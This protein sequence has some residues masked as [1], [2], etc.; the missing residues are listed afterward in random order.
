MR[1]T[2][3][4]KE[5]TNSKEIKNGVK[6]KR[7]LGFIPTITFTSQE[8]D[9]FLKFA[10]GDQALNDPISSD[11]PFERSQS[12]VVPSTVIPKS[13]FHP[14]SG[15]CIQD[16]NTKKKYLLSHKSCKADMFCDICEKVFCKEECKEQHKAFPCRAI[17][18]YHFGE[19]ITSR[20]EDQIENME[21]TEDEINHLEDEV[22]MMERKLNI[23]YKSQK[24][25]YMFAVKTLQ[26]SI[27]TKLKLIQ[28]EENDSRLLLSECKG[29]MMGNEHNI[30]TIRSFGVKMREHWE[31]KHYH[32]IYASRNKI[33]KIMKVHFEDLPI[34]LNDIMTEANQKIGEILGKGEKIKEFFQQKFDDL[35]DFLITTKDDLVEEMAVE[36]LQANFHISDRVLHY[37]IEDSH[38]FY[39]FDIESL[40]GKKMEVKNMKIPYGFDSIQ[41]NSERIFLCGGYES[42]YGDEYLKSTYEFIEESSILLR[43]PDMQHAKVYHHLVHISH[44]NHEYVYCIG[45]YEDEILNICEKYDVKQNK[46][47]SSP[48]PPRLK[49]HRAGVS[50]CQIEAQIYV[51]GGSSGEKMY[52]LSMERL[53]LHHENRGWEI[54]HLEETGGLT[55]RRDAGLVPIGAHQ[56]LIFGGW[57]GGYERHSDESFI[58]D[59]ETHSV[60]RTN[61]LKKSD[62][63]GRQFKSVIDHD[64]IY[65]QGADNKDVHIYSVQHGN[66]KILAHKYI[67]S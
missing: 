46:W 61:P 12:N 32:R 33:E 26:E 49:V 29:K 28:K 13:G 67:H 24:E 22:A 5:E 37:F 43:R 40:K 7:V 31:N 52:F 17:D 58:Y 27:Q 65:T 36:K 45:G 38:D 3:D 54:I 66:W 2:E 41:L 48:M 42:L 60:T 8:S 25:F 56:L 11:Y 14:K 50:A 23:H 19:K 10:S 51:F 53:N 39:L 4:P 1:K 9:T 30:E 44:N 34:K 35:N 15:F 47:I 20:L 18:L 55:A 57:C 59:L 64:Y 62:C 21:Q 6:D 16:S 63:F